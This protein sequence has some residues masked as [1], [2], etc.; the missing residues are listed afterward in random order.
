M[1][2]VLGIR[3]GYAGRVAQ[4]VDVELLDQAIRRSQLWSRN[5]RKLWVKVKVSKK[6]QKLPRLLKDSNSRTLH[7]ATP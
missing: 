1:L 3:A 2:L 6:S 7:Q 5:D 4:T